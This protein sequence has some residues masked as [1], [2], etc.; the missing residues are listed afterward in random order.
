MN[1]YNDLLEHLNEGETI[2]AIVFGEWGWGTGWKEPANSVPVEKRGVILTEEEAKP[3]M[4]GWSFNGG[5][6]SPECHAVNVWTNQRLFWVTQYDGMTW[7]DSAPRN[8][9]AYMPDMPG[10]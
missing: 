9:T 4:K 10:G 8:P 2:E 1:A 3:L 6:G 7:I 5:H